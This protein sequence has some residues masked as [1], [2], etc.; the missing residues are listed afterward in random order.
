MWCISNCTITIDDGDLLFREN[1]TIG[2]KIALTEKIVSALRKMKCPARLEPHQIQGE[3]FKNIFPAVQWLVKKVI[4]TRELMGDHRRA[5]SISQFDKFYTIPGDDV[6][7]NAS[8]FE[9][10]KQQYRPK[11]RFKRV[12]KGTIDAEG[13]V[14]S[15]LLEYG[16]VSSASTKSTATKKGGIEGSAVA[17]ETSKN[18]EADAVEKEEDEEDEEE[19]IRRQQEHNLHALMGAMSE[20]TGREAEGKAASRVV[21][22]LIVDG[23]D[24]INAIAT[25][26]ADKRA[27]LHYD[28]IAELET[29]IEK[30]ETLM[31]ARQEENDTTQSQLDTALEDNLH[32]EGEL[33]DCRE[34][35]QAIDQEMARLEA[36]ER[37]A[38]RSH[39]AKIRELVSQVEITK[40]EEAEFKQKCKK[41]DV[42]LKERINELKMQ[43]KKREEIGVE[44]DDTV[45]HQ[46]ETDHQKLSKV[47][48]ALAAKNR[49]AAT[50]MRKIDEVP[51][52]AELT[53]YQK[54]F[55]ELYDQIAVTHVE[56]KQFYTM[57]NTLD[58]TRR[59]LEKE[60]DLLDSIYD[61]FQAATGSTVSMKQYLEQFEK[62]VAGVKS[63]KAKVEQKRQQE[64]MRRDELNEEYHDLLEKHR[65]YVKTIQ[66]F[67]QECR[68]N[69]I[70]VSK[71]Q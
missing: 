42:E 39:V 25:E 60:A 37:D 28:P 62:I 67:Q 7:L 66:E 65:Q 32:I 40:R 12:E 24:E 33:A 51:T 18:N 5:Y 4:E 21:G 57:Y 9:A 63:N 23:A 29:Q 71:L 69:E 44:N 35:L 70:L 43:I 56:T 2:Q 45:K 13:R 27:Q 26:F 20:L 49:R 16:R 52:R 59:Y 10:L 58:D 6:G 15:T 50:L 30:F 68:K 36:I 14:S 61:N 19:R 3:D 34:T 54:R 47:R 22:S 64:K 31:S 53:Q 8:A 55:V 41:E 1:A 11:R 48:L 46:L 17:A 38:D